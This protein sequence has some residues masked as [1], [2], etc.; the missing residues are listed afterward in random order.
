MG[1]RTDLAGQL[2][3]EYSTSDESF[4]FNPTKTAIKCGGYI[5]TDTNHLVGSGI[6]HK[7]QVDESHIN[8]NPI[9][10]EL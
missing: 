10:L 9:V 7:S 6:F 1:R 4:C 5:D 3:S 2:W 8:H